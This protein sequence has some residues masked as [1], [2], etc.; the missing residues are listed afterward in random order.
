MLLLQS[1]AVVTALPLF[2]S[3]SYGEKHVV[4]ILLNTI[5]YALFPNVGIHSQINLSC[6]LTCLRHEQ[7]AVVVI[8][9][10]A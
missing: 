7:T 3:V 6:R 8:A 2:L 1:L 10:T 4:A 5:L 9:Y